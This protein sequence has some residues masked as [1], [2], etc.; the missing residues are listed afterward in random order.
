MSD[1]PM[2]A[3]SKASVASEAT[4]NNEDRSPRETKISNFV[5]QF[6]DLSDNQFLLGDY[7]RSHCMQMSRC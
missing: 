7:G 3:S 1:P 2:A 5:W 4:C 6:D